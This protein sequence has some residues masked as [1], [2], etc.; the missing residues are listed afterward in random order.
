MIIEAVLHRMLGEY[1][2]SVTRGVEGV[3]TRGPRQVGVEAVE[4]VVETVAEQHR[5]E[6]TQHGRDHHHA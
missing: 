6:D 3:S 4:H 5:V 1:R 2:S